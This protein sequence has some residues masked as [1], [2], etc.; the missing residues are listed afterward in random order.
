MTEASAAP[1]KEKTVNWTDPKIMEPL[2]NQIIDAEKEAFMTVKANVKENLAMG[3]SAKSYNQ[4]EVWMHPENG[5]LPKL[6]KLSP[7]FRNLTLPKN[8]HQAALQAVERFLLKPSSAALYTP[9][10]E[11]AEPAPAGRTSLLNSG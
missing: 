1:P 2:L 6:V 11:Q 10:M 3:I 9:G 5:I 8:A 7:P 4:K